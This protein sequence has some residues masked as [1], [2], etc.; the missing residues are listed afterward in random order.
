MR[1][2]AFRPEVFAKAPTYSDKD[3]NQLDR[4]NVAW[5]NL[6]NKIQMAFG[7][8]TS[9]HG[10]ELVKDI[11]RITTGLI[12]LAEVLTVIGEKLGIFKLPAMAIEGWTK[13]FESVKDIGDGKTTK[14][15]LWGGLK[16]FLKYDMSGKANEGMFRD[17]EWEDQFQ[18]RM[19]G[20]PSGGT[21]KTENTTFNQTLNFQH[22]GRDAKRTSESVGKSVKD[23]YRQIQ[24]QGQGS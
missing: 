14:S 23:A 12:K 10:M 19:G 4:V 1:R 24:A 11:D 13:I 9:R 18:K 3:I 8:F 6:G 17:K 2:N 16:E 21:Q 20:K 22:D 5:G 15:D 7:K